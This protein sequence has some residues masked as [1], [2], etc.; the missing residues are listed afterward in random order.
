MTVARDTNPVRKRREELGIKPRELAHTLGRNAAFVSMMEGGFVP[1][2]DR[3]AQVA[4]ALATTAQEL[5]PE[6]YR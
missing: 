4:R 1:S 3:R 6:E 2:A 5:W